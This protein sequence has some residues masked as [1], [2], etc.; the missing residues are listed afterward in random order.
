[1]YYEM[2]ERY[3]NEIRKLENQLK[4]AKQQIPSP[5]TE[6]LLNWQVTEA[7][8]TLAARRAELR[9]WWSALSVSVVTGVGSWLLPLPVGACLTLF[10]LACAA[11]VLSGVN[12]WNGGPT[13]ASMRLDLAKAEHKLSTYYLD[14]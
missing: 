6:A 13:V 9:R 14:Q 7:R 11:L 12:I 10:G 3:E 2:Y 1:M 5:N 8:M 4:L